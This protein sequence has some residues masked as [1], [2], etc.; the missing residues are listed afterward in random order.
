MPSPIID[1]HH[2]N[3]HL[4]IIDIEGIKTLK[5]KDSVDFSHV[6]KIDL[7]GV[8]DQIDEIPDELFYDNK[9]DTSL[10]INLEE[11]DIRNTNIRRIGKSA[12][13]KIPNLHTIS[14]NNV[15]YSI[16]DFAFFE[17]TSLSAEAGLTIPDTVENIYRKA[18]HNTAVTQY[19]YRGSTITLSNPD[20]SNLDQTLGG[21]LYIFT[22]NKYTVP[23]NVVK[24]GASTFADLNVEYVTLNSNILYLGTQSFYGSSIIELVIPNSVVNIESYSLA[25]THKLSSLTLSNSITSLPPYFLHNSKLINLNIPSTVQT[26]SEYSISSYTE[27]LIFS[28]GSPVSKNNLNMNSNQLFHPKLKIRY[29][30]NTNE[31]K[32]LLP[33]LYILDKIVIILVQ[34]DVRTRVNTV[35]KQLIKVK[36]L[37]DNFFSYYVLIKKKI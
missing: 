9:T 1:S 12:F 11:L 7:S 4:E 13:R 22:N 28:N 23:L 37:N 27:T 35:G 21:F 30:A 32:N 18:F 24:I 19:L 20:F 33:V 34:L 26:L 5:R 31:E 15:L 25:A 14:F 36:Y 29:I 16:G 2:F 3:N 10:I 6:T 17:C 8:T